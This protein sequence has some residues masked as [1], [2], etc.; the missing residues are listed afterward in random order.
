MR[1]YEHYGDSGFHT[2]IATTFGLDF[3]AYENIV[4]PRLRG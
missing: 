3:D 1:L 2:C 4:L